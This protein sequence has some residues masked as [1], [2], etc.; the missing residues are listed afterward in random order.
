MLACLLFRLSAFSLCGFLWVFSNATALWST[1]TGLI[2]TGRQACF[3]AM[4][5]GLAVFVQVALG[6]EGEAAGHAGV[7]PLAR[8]RADVLLQD[9]GLGASSATV[10]TDVLSGF[11]RFLLFFA[12]TLISRLGA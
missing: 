9:A 8:V 7:R 11:F 10:V 2:T 4:G 6:L 5:M 12:I 1:Q 3:Y